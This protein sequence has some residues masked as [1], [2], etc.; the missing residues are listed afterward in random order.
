MNTITCKMKVSNF[1]LIQKFQNNPKQCTHPKTLNFQIVFER[2]SSHFELF[3][4][5]FE[6]FSHH[7]LNLVGAIVVAT[8]FL[9]SSS[10][11]RSEKK[12]EKDVQQIWTNIEKEWKRWYISFAFRVDDDADGK[13]DCD[14]PDCAYLCQA[15]W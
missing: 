4:D 9:A 2:L 11:D 12:I 15:D 14:D 1:I 5:R 8:L 3:W 6:S 13:A 7:F 10:I